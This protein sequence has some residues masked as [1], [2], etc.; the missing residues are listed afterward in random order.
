[1]N[2]KRYP[3][4][5]FKDRSLLEKST[6]FLM[7]GVLVLASWFV[8]SLKINSSV[9]QYYSKIPSRISAVRQILRDGKIINRV[10]PTKQFINCVGKVTEVSVNKNQRVKVVN[11]RQVF[12][13]IIDG[14][15]INFIIYK[16]WGQKLA[17]SIALNYNNTF[18]I[19]TFFD[20]SR[21]WYVGRIEESLYEEFNNL[22]NKGV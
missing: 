8:L 12:E 14:K 5:D 6:V 2:K 3:N 20:F 7:L 15:K 11:I 18:Y 13:C 22:Y 21:N 9:I 1:M 4:F 10:I 16:D 17:Y 19:D